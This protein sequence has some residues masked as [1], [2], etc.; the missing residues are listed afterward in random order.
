[1]L[2][3]NEPLKDMGKRVRPLMEE[4]VEI[5]IVT[6]SAQVLVEADSGRWTR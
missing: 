3:L 6:K 4:D 5:V 1:M 2:D